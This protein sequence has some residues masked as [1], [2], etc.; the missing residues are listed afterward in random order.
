MKLIRSSGVLCHVTSL[1]S[2]FGV[3]DL[4]SEAYRFA[5]WLGRA[6]QSRWQIL[7]LNPT[8]RAKNNSPYDSDSAFA[9]DP[10]VLSP[11]R[12]VEEGILTGDDLAD[13]PVFPDNRVDY[14]TVRQYKG[15]LYAV[16]CGRLKTA[17]YGNEF[18]WFCRE[19][20]F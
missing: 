19:N 16:A 13:A 1:P 6:R 9:L 11:E 4:G 15:T 3:G 5:D 10:L 2:R 20:R 8:S 17:G 18:E 14:E 7:P 12:L